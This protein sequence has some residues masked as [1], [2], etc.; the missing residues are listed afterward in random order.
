MG[1][2]EI[3]PILQQLIQGQTPEGWDLQDPQTWRG[4]IVNG[5]FT[6]LILVANLVFHNGADEFIV[7]VDGTKDF[8]R[9]YEITIKVLED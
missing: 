7:T 3:T 5:I 8:D 1:P 9:R 2:D 6:L 4:S